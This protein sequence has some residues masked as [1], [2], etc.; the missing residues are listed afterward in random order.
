[1][2]TYVVG[3]G[4]TGGYFGGRLAAAGGNVTFV[5]RGD[6]CRAMRETGLQVKSAHGD[7]TI[8]RPQVID[9]PEKI[10]NPELIL[11]FVKT[12]DTAEVA[13]GL[14][15]VIGAGTTVITFQTGLENDFEIMKAVGSRRVFPGLVYVNSARVAPGVIR[16][17]SGPCTMTFGRRGGAADPGL[18]RVEKLFRE[19]G[20]DAALTRGIEGEMWRK[21]IWI[22]AFA[23]MTVLFRA[24]VGRI[25][26]NPGG[27]RMFRNCLEEALAV[28]AARGIKFPAA[29][30]DRIFARIDYYKGPG[31]D[32]V[33]SL[34]LD[35]ENGRRTEIETL[36]GTLVRFAREAG[37][38][39][40]LLE[41]VYTVVQVHEARVAAM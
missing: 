5:A 23:G 7:F 35:I 21:L 33:T 25:L 30:R 15:G 22:S 34:L 1:M 3:A 13:R 38:E 2:K 24:P 9:T 27:E 20:I 8:D 16:Q 39:I 31:A 37:V 10:Q 17:A 4:A 26:G 41:T 12:Y 28:A 40:P 18:E 32:A 6:H 19:A 36:H 14:A 29:E 11:V